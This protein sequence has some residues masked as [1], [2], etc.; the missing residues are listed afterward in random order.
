MSEVASLARVKTPD[1]RLLVERARQVAAA[2]AARAADK[3]EDGAFPTEDIAALAHAGLLMAPF[4]SP[5]GGNDL[6]IGD[7]DRLRE[8]LTAIGRGSL[9]LGRLYEGHVNA[10]VLTA[11][12]G[13]HANLRLLA[14]EAAAGMPSGVWMAGEPLRLEPDGTCFVL[15]GRKILCSGS[16]HFR[17]PLV[18]ADRADGSVMVIPA[19]DAERADA[20]RWTA[21]GMR[22]TATGTVDFDGIAVSPDEIVG[23]PGDYLRA[24]YFRGG[25][26]RVIAVQLGGLEAVLEAYAAQVR[27]SPH[28]DHPL[29]LARYGQAEIACETARLWVAK[30]ACVAEGPV[31]DADAIDATVDLA[32][33][34]FEAA[35]L[36]VVALAQKAVG[37]RSF[38]RPNPLERL[39]RDLTTYLRQPN[40]DVS[41]MS[42]AAFRLRESET[43]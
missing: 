24:P 1:G 10:V 32:R 15:R 22:A 11:R 31:A 18:A 42:A 27:A 36:E 13:S 14:A 2:A 28:R 33:N 30:A 17:R 26:W 43:R 8:M 12:Y 39:I 40:L 20:S 41:L 6:G 21:H 25:A 9:S 4:P 7:P 37:L 19:V 5:F 23:D 29:Q 38:L 34:A 35:A 3:D 16:G